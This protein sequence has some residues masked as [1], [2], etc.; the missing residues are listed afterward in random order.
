MRNTKVV[1][2]LSGIIAL[3]FGLAAKRSVVTD[4]QGKLGKR[5]TVNTQLF[6]ADTR[7]GDSKSKSGA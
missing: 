4:F 1:I 6:A 3:L 5:I 2:I 7:T